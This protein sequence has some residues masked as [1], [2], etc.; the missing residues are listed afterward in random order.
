MNPLAVGKPMKR[1]IVGGFARNV[2]EPAGEIPT[3]ANNSG[4]E[5]PLMYPTPGP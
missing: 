5:D 1:R 4:L 2:L 3:S